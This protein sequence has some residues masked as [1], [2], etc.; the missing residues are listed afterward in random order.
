[1]AMD[2]AERLQALHRYAILDT[3][4]EETFARLVRLCA[5]SL[6]VPMAAIGF[7][8]GQRIWLKASHGLP[9]REVPREGAF[10]SHAILSDDVMV[11]PSAKE[12]PRFMN[13]PFVIGKPGIQFYAGCPLRTPGGHRIG[14]LCALDLV[15]RE[16]S[17]EKRELMRDVSALVMHAL[18]SRLSSARAARSEEAFTQAEVTF[19]SYLH[20]TPEAVVI[21]RGGRVVHVNPS[22]ILLLD[23]GRPEDVVGRHFLDIVHSEDRAKES[24]RIRL[25][26]TGRNL[27]SEQVRWV[28]RRGDLAIVDAFSIHRR[29]EGESSVVTIAHDVT[30]QKR[31][32]D[33]LRRS[34]AGFRALIECSPDAIMVHRD[35]RLVYANP[36]SSLLLGFP[37]PGVMVGSTLAE[38]VHLESRGQLMDRLRTLESSRAPT[39]IMEVRLLRKDRMVVAVEMVALMV[40]FDGG[41]AIVTACRDIT[42][43]KQ[44]HARLLSADRMASL[45]T[46][47]SGIA[48]EINNPLSS[49][50]A[51]L[52]FLSEELSELF[53]NGSA[54]RARVSE[55]REMLSEAVMGADRVRKIVKDL[56]IFARGDEDRRQAVDVRKVLDSTLN[57]AAN[58]LR[59]RAR[60]IKDFGDVLPVNASESRLGQVFLNLVMN[61]VHAVPEGAA[62]RN[63]IRVTTRTDGTG[64]VVVEMADTGSGIRPDIRS[65]IFDPF[66]TTKPVGIGTGLGLSICQGII[67]SLGGEIQVESEIGKGSMFRVLLPGIAKSA[68]SVPPVLAS[69]AMSK[70]ARILVIDDEPLIGAVFRRTLGREHEVVFVTSA[71]EAVERIVEKRETFDLVFCDLMMPE[72]TGMDLHAD[73]QVRYPELLAKMIFLTGGAFTARA[74]EFLDS[75]PNPCIE[76]PFDP[77][78]LLTLVGK[79]L[80]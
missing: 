41:P 5:N 11:V 26:M 59:H 45:G 9:M 35:G 7:V 42:E 12:D 48:H 66:F 70:R 63:E 53:Q 76:K 47:S 40:D 25:A 6:G 16:L 67:N 49:V 17:H 30:E 39:P 36:A 77:A 10:C 43:R 15:P 56:K 21:H 1:M 28:K 44:V 4:E 58:E 14:T 24:E 78:M 29:F 65:R 61:A 73:L 75:V 34:E 60:L 55:V 13:H 46:L 52:G 68:A 2:E 32:T 8:D 50:I 54:S 31:A 57:V 18:S 23:L 19:R 38:L 74:Q 27:P 22:L 80:G 62:E 33:A 20:H 64:R 79:R 37:H 51:N 3:P 69:T 72:V 71:K